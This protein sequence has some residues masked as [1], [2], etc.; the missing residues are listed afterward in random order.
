[1][2]VVTYARVSTEEQALDGTSLD[3]QQEQLHEYCMRQGH[4]IIREYRD[5]GFSGKNGDRPRLRE[6]LWAA[7]NGIFEGIVVTKLDRLARNLRLLLELE[8][9]LKSLGVALYSVKDNV[10]TSTPIGRTV[11]QVLGLV[12]EWEREAI[13]ERT[14]GGRLRRYK[15]GRWGPGRVA[16]GYQYNEATKK[17]VI[18]EE[19]AKIVKKIFDL[20]L[21]GKGMMKIC[22]VL[23]R[24]GI[25]PRTDRAKG[26]HSAAIRD[27]LVNPAY[28]GELIVNRHQPVSKLRK[29]TPQTAIRIEV[30]PIVDRDIWQAA[31][32]RLSSNKHVRPARVNPWLLQGLVVCGECG[33]SFRGDIT[34]GK[35]YYS[36][37]GRLKKSHV[38][39]SIRCTVPRISADWLEDQ[40]W[41][42]IQAM[43]D[44]PSTLEKLLCDTIE[45]LKT[46]GSELYSRIRPID[47]RLTE[48]AERKK[49]LA[50]SWVESALGQDQVDR[51]RR[52]LEEEEARLK[53]IKGET[54]PA[55][56]DELQRSQAMLR[57]WQK[58]L[59]S[60]S[61]NLLDENGKQIRLVD[62]PHR[63][64]RQIVNLEDKEISS[65]M[66]FP[67]S[68]REMLD[69]LQI[70]VV[71]FGDRAEVKGILPIE[72]IESLSCSS[73]C[74][75]GSCPRCL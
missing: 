63:V 55:Q 1:M 7:E 20:Y 8:E 71:V 75:S 67:A 13:I 43:L 19:Q 70:R 45:R 39:G 59:D 41:S 14:R 35:R 68:R 21:S 40:V 12:A 10:N 64:V 46:R 24:E 74:A 60:M 4:E 17:L 58:H 25:L 31:Q 6:L 57:F 53:C 62:Q 66:Q 38:D 29:D 5:A 11:F 15:E 65:I 3:D 33:H 2:R 26:W 73:G 48:I 23:G 34:H 52:Q 54:D 28:K 16:Y 36:C 30:P 49:K 32:R 72:G 22:D 42:R 56:L 44:E 51:Q 50:E 9:R 69:H 61:W 37:I 18:H 27:V 47:E